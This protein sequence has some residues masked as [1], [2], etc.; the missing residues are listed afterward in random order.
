MGR[1]SRLLQWGMN[2]LRS[3]VFAAVDTLAG[4][5]MAT[6]IGGTAAFVG[7]FSNTMKPKEK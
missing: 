1:E 6:F 5:G 7:G 3:A 4:A 2:L